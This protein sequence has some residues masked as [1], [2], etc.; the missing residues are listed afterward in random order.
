VT[1]WSL[2]QML[3]VGHFILSKILALLVM[4][5]TFLAVLWR[6]SRYSCSPF[7]ILTC[8]PVVVIFWNVFRLSSLWGQL[9][10]WGKKI[11]QSWMKANFILVILLAWELFLR[12]VLIMNLYRSIPC[13]LFNKRFICSPKVCLF[14]KSWYK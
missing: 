5:L 10:L 12:F 8:I 1:Q 14:Q 11:G 3:R 9:F 2:S 4:N 7:I 13:V 6:Y